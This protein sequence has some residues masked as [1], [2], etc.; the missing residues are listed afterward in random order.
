MRLIALCPTYLTLSATSTNKY[1]YHHIDD[2][3]NHLDGSSLSFAGIMFL[4]YVLNTQLAVRFNEGE[5][6][7]EVMKAAGESP[8]PAGNPHGSEDSSRKRRGC[9]LVGSEE[10]N[11]K[12]G[13]HRCLTGFT[14]VEEFRS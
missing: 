12:P 8:S 9:C 7:P 14:D 11:R 10:G 5:E 2:Y 3:F 4:F 6:P 1:Q 13:P